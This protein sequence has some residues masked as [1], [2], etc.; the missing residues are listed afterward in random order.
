MNSRMTVGKKLALIGAFLITLTVTLGVSTLIG[1][2]G[3]NKIVTS[4]AGDSLAGVSECSKVEAALLELRGDAW[5]HIASADPKTIAE[6]DQQIQKLKEQIN[7]GLADVEKAIFQDEER[8]INLKIKPALERYY[9]A[10]DGVAVIS[11]TG[12]NADATKKYM[13]EANTAYITAKEAIDL[14]TEF[15]RKSGAV[16]TAAAASTGARMKWLTWLIL[17]ISVVAGSG[18]FYFVVRNINQVLNR[19]VSELAEGAEQITSASSQVASSSQSLAQGASEQAA[20]LEETA[21]SS[22]EITSMTRKNAENSK[23]AASMMSEVDRNIAQ[24]NQTLG[25]M[26]TSMREI[27]SS[28]DK[29]SKIIKVI[30]EIAF[31]TNILALNA[32]VE[33]ARAGEAGMGF[34]V[35]ADE[36]RNLAQRSAQAAK[37][38]AALIEESIAKSNEGST[39]LQQVTGVIQAITES[40]T[41]VKTLVDEVSLGSQEQ[42]RGIEQISK[43]IAQMD[44]VTQSTA[45][46][47]EESASAS[48]EMSAQAEALNHIVVQLRSLIGGNGTGTES[49]QPVRRAASKPVTNSLANLKSAV[50]R[51]DSKPLEVPVPAGE[52]SE[53]P[54]EDNFTEM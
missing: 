2:A 4:L 44:Q 25:Q 37:D 39:K 22:Q 48:E 1:L 12:N 19:T 45:A 9:Q 17:I 20:S 51:R 27:T 49:R 47:A 29:I 41:K 11:R 34:A 46:N 5:K 10:W 42:A 38:T 52:Y 15:N 30:D 3:F 18:I 16:N 36:V 14:E 32:A 54:M 53:F 40:A 8:Q 13:A 50:S 6:M 31:Q 28:S 7:A 35:V 21:A 26:V 24:G 23:S 43:A 33:A